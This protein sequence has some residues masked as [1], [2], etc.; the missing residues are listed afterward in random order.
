VSAPDRF[1]AARRQRIMLDGVAARP[2]AW[3]HCM[4]G[5]LAYYLSLDTTGRCPACAPLDSLPYA[6]VSA[7]RA[8]RL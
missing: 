4:C 8:V 3:T 5:R 1:D 7:D 2:L 6:P